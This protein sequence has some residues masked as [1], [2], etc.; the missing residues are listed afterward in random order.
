MIEQRYDGGP[1]FPRPYSSGSQDQSG[2]SLLDYFAGQA[3]QGFLAA[4]D[5]GYAG[6]KDVESLAHASYSVAVAMISERENRNVT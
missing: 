6:W 1:V 5:E 2:M 3:M 4:N